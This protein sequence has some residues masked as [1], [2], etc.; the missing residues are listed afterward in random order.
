MT[1]RLSCTFVIFAA[2]QFA[3][4]GLLPAPFV[5][6]QASACIGSGPGIQCSQAPSGTLT[7]GGETLGFTDQ[8]SALF[9][10]MHIA[11]SANFTNLSND[12]AFSIGYAAIQDNLVINSATK[13]GQ[14]GNL[15]ISYYLDGTVSKSGAG[16]AFNQV[17]ATVTNPGQAMQNNIDDY[18]GTVL[19]GTYQVPLVFHFVYG[20]SFT[21]YFS[22]QATTGTV[23]DQGGVG[24][25]V[26]NAT[27]SGSGSANFF[28]TFVLNGLNT[29][30]SDAIYSGGSTNYGASGVA[31]EPATFALSGAALI[32]V[33][34]WRRKKA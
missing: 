20:T 13:N 12:Q 33:A 4:A 17:V 21:L 22:M 16:N 24:Y 8:A 7:S 25:S 1:K 32:A 18:Q 19:P 9:G 10:I 2:S 28:N 6:T 30:A 3:A 23:F 31:P 5:V 34:L 11:A 29:D 14:V 15:V 26:V 27:G